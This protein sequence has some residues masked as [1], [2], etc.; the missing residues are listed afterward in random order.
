MNLSNE[1]AESCE[2]IVSDTLDIVAMIHVLERIETQCQSQKG[3]FVF[4]A[5]IFQ[6]DFYIVTSF[7]D[8]CEIV[9]KTELLESFKEVFGEEVATGTLQEVCSF[10]LLS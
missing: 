4:R 10:A 3:L 5:T 6:H 8:Q 2:S 9:L 7:P 1:F